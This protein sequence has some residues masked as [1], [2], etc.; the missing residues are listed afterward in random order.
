M[1]ADIGDQTIIFLGGRSD[2]GVA[3][4][5]VRASM[6]RVNLFIASGHID[7]DIDVQIFV[8]PH[9]LVLARYLV[10]VDGRLVVVGIRCIGKGCGR[11]HPSHHGPRQQHADPTLDRIIRQCKHFLSKTAGGAGRGE[12]EAPLPLP[13]VASLGRCQVLGSESELILNRIGDIALAIHTIVVGVIIEPH[14][15]VGAAG[16][17]AGEGHAIADLFIRNLLPLLS[18]DIVGLNFAPV[19]AAMATHRGNIEGI[20]GDVAIDSR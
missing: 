7:A 8:R 3:H 6:H 20:L 13:A 17:R 11:E 5:R 10:L 2:V 14:L 9:Q 16:K 15:R 19:V 1:A 18:E 12:E 4:M